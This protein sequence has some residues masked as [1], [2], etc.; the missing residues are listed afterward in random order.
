MPPR[1]TYWTGTWDPRQ[2]A[3]SKEVELLRSIG[4]HLR[5]VVSFS[6]GQEW[7]VDRR[8][9]VV[10]L[11]AN[12]W[13]LL[14]AVARAVERTASITHVFG[15]LDSWHLLRA[16]GGRPVVLTAALSG[17][18]VD[19]TLW[20]RVSLFVAESDRLRAELR[21]SGIPA[22]RIR[23]IY[24][25]IDLHEYRPGPGPSLPESRFR[26]LFASSPADPREFE[27]RGISLLVEVARACPEI[28]VVLLWRDWGSREEAGRALARLAPPHNVKIERADGREMPSIY[29]SSDAVA[30]LYDRDFGK[31]CPNSVVEALGCGIPAIVSNSIGIAP[32]LSDSH[33]GLAV[34]RDVRTVVDAVRV[35]RDRHHSFARGARSLAERAFDVRQFLH[36]YEGVYAELS[37]CEQAA[38]AA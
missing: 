11:G 25:G 16:V 17:R 19:A 28:D 18:S 6:S 5:P 8:R 31:S 33:A 29:R 3:I 27:V 36:G 21:E 7:R 24:P 14:R 26:L 2:E 30:C 32:L 10:Q 12:Q 34:A 38:R 20:S 22:D 9:R 37:V 1:V 15:S 23:L 13:W 4:G 35:M